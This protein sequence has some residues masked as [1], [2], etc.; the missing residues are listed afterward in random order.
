[1]DDEAACLAADVRA[2]S[3]LVAARCAEAALV[4]ALDA[5]LA[6][7]RAALPR[8]R[9]HRAMLALLRAALDLVLARGTL[10]AG[11][12]AVLARG[13][14]FARGAIFT[15]QRAFGQRKLPDGALETLERVR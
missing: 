6:L 5:C 3:R 12:M 8:E 4:L 1:M 11:R 10:F 9:V 13:A 7:E 2:A 15:R 14:V